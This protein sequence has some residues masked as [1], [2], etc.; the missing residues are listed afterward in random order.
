[1]LIIRH[2][3][4]GD[5]L[6]GAEE[7]IVDAVDA[8]YRLHDQGRSALPHSVFLRF[9]D[10]PR[11]RVIGLPGYL[12]G[13]PATAGMKWIASFPGN[14]E[15]G[16]ERASAVVVLND[17]RTGRPLA[18]IEGSRISAK[19]TAASAALAARLLTGEP[20]PAGVTLVGCGVIN[21]EVLRF[22]RATLPSI[23]DVTLYD[24][25]VRRAGRFAAQCATLA[26]DAVITVAED[27][28]AALAAHR[29]VS[30]AT[31]AAEP[32]TDLAACAPGTTVL[33][34]SLRDI[35]PT[36]LLCARNV[37]DDADHVC[38][39]RTSVH[40]AEQVA[41][42]RDFIDASIGQL[43]NKD[44]ELDRTT[45]GLTVFSPFGLGILDLALA[46]LVHTEAAGRGLGVAVDGFLPPARP[47]PNA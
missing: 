2:T 20:A 43:L 8:A 6:Q 24:Q 12:G 47:V 29:L 15:R 16:L 31:T 9:P 7:R 45:D 23:T 3:D 27:L 32:Y 37:V 19:R 17:T 30:L 39:E 14:L 34:V 46:R 11:D 1:M 21:L 28:D 36:T 26:P 22:L 25:D 41:G 35:A 13:E 33:N 38:R 42:N 18:L 4:V 5:I 44:V 10:A 40:L